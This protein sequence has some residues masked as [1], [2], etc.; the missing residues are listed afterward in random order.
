M[1][2]AITRKAVTVVAAVALA[3]FGT[4]VPANAQEVDA[5]T[6]G[7][8]SASIATVLDPAVFRQL[9]SS[10]ENGE[11]AYYTTVNGYDL[12][13]QKDTDARTTILV[14][15][16]GVVPDDPNTPQML[17]A[18]TTA[19]TAAIFGLGSAV[20]GALA[21]I[22]AP[23]TI[24]GVVIAPEV[25]SLLAAAMGSYSAVEALVAEFIC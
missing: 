13:V 6:S 4:A 11:R 25:L 14:V 22:G 20:I 5:G 15:P 10:L 1:K 9:Q 8:Y 23:I 7:V 17:S 16:Q 21:V 2:V 24:A 12:Y 19:V 18:C 3:A